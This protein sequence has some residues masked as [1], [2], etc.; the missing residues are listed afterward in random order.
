MFVKIKICGITNVEDASISVDYGADAIGFVFYPQSSRY[1]SP[2]KAAQITAIMP[3]FVSV[4]GIFVDASFEFIKEV[5]NKVDIDVV[6]LHGNE[7]PDFC[8]MFDC[9]IIKA[10]R[11]QNAETLEVCKNYLNISWLLDAFNPDLI[12][13]TGKVFDWQ[14][15]LKARLLNPR[16]ILSG[17]LTPENVADA[18]QKVRPMAVDVSS[19]IEKSPGKKDHQKLKAFIKAAKLALVEF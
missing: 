3:P 11:I 17:G 5:I 2:D 1:I 6:Q 16:I 14:I 18:I 4:V 12:G 9:K 13:G 10:F 19:G 7:S 15:A 8:K